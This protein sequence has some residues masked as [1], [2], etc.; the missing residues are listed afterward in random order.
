MK[1]VIQ[2]LKGG[3]VSVVDVPVPSIAPGQVLVK[4][5]ASLVSVGTE[6]ALLEFAQKNLLSKAL[7]RPD[8]VRQ[9]VEKAKSDGMLSAFDSAKGRLSQPIA[10][11]YSS[12]GYV[13]EASGSASI[14]KPG[15]RVACAGSGYASHAEFITVPENLI[16]KIPGEMFR[17]RSWPNDWV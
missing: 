4:N 6:R 5:M 16:A 9:V 13:V 15:D 10:L 11:G 8:L 2:N 7:E 17:E 1:Q 3:E 14:F 12:A